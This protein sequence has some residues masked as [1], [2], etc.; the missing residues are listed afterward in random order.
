[1]RVPKVFKNDVVL[2]FDDRDAD[3]T[4]YL[5]LHVR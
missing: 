4:L 5:A 1:V 3:E 2:A